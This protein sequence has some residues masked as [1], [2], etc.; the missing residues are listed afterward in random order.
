[1]RCTFLPHTFFKPQSISWIVVSGLIL[2]PSLYSS[3]PHPTLSHNFSFI[4]R[5]SPRI[6][7]T[8]IHSRQLCQP[9][10]QLLAPWRQQHANLLT[11]PSDRHHD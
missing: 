3:Y 11:T 1:M 5:C 9:N 8:L 10:P 7:F 6:C 4:S 2:F